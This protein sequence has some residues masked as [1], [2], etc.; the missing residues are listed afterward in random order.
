MILRKLGMVLCAVAL[1]TACNYDDEF[2]KLNQE[3]GGLNDRLESLEGQVEGLTELVN[4]TQDIQNRLAALEGALTALPESSALATGV[5]E[6][7]ERLSDI[8]A[9][10]GNLD[11]ESGG[12]QGEI[13]ALTADLEEMQLE[14]AQLLE[15]NNVYPGDLVITS[16]AELDAI[17]EFMGDWETLI[18]DGAVLI[19]PDFSYGMV[20]KAAGFGDIS[21]KLYAVT[22]KIT[23]I[24]GK[25]LEV[26][27]PVPGFGEYDEEGFFG[28]FVS[29]NITVA[30]MEVG[31]VDGD[32]L[33]PE[34]RTVNGGIRVFDVA[35]TVRMPL[36][37]V[38]PGFSWVSA[39]SGGY[40]GFLGEEGTSSLY[41]EYIEGDVEL[42]SLNVVDSFT[43]VDVDGSV[44]VSNLQLAKA[45]LAVTLVD[46]F[47]AGQLR[48]VRGYMDLE[49]GGGY[50]FPLL[51]KVSYGIR[52]VDFGLDNPDGGAPTLRVDFPALKELGEPIQVRDESPMGVADNEFS[53]ATYVNILGFFTNDY[54]MEA[55]LA[56][57][58][59]GFGAPLAET[60]IINGDTYYEEG[61]SMIRTDLA[62]SAP[63]AAVTLTFTEASAYWGD[64]DGNLLL[65]FN[66]L[67]ADSLA[68]I[69]GSLGLFGPAD[70]VANQLSVSLPELYYIYGVVEVEVGFLRTENLYALSIPKYEETTNINYTSND[71][72][73]F[74]A[75][76][77][78][79]D[80]VD[81][82]ALQSLTLTALE[83]TFDFEDLDN[84]FGGLDTEVLTTVNITG[85]NCDASVI[86]DA[87]DSL[88]VPGNGTNFNALES[89]T[90]SGIFSQVTVVG[91]DGLTSISTSGEITSWDFAD[92]DAVTTFN[93]TH[94]PGSCTDN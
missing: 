34:L 61:E 27:Y 49:Y 3:L 24:L 79:D 17:L 88:P 22:S 65:E 74:T 15:N 86:I 5:A 75:A 69:D 14:L 66:S 44:D 67:Q 81:F 90:L 63:N 72:V 42:S 33:F 43:A 94:T 21:E 78:T 68:Y 40:Y 80:R 9:S 1:V 93:I 46:E 36:M 12:L 56:A 30:G 54:N 85:K 57:D 83:T 91:A 6:L 11:P 59:N 35:G 70:G 60:V 45:D 18:V 10:L 32:L 52:L 64:G 4:G 25:N 71:L 2:D 20:D 73:Q 29:E 16:E 28:F 82:G 23:S 92:N 13:D 50:V 26:S 76:S 19:A 48:E 89:L 87:G 53:N 62:V 51:E 55:A 38:V 39:I 41:F 7:Q 37:D 47:L 84:G 58:V 8:E 31:G 77:I